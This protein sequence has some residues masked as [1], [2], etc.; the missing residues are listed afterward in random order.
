MDDKI[1][2]TAEDFFLEKINIYLKEKKIS[3]KSLSSHMQYSEMHVGLI[4]NKRKK[5]T[6]KFVKSL[7]LSLDFLA[8]HDLK[9]LKNIVKNSKWKEYS[10]LF[11]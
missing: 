4:L 2:L 3:K 10:Y 9:K 11:D 5:L 8:K 6:K 1:N 7:L